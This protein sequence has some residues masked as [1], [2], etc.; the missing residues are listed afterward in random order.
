MSGLSLLNINKAAQAQQVLESTKTVS[1]RIDSSSAPVGVDGNFRPGVEYSFSAQAG[2]EVRIDAVRDETTSMDI[3]M[4]VIPPNSSPIKLDSDLD[5]FRRETYRSS[6]VTT[7]GTW[8]VRI[9]SFDRKPGTFQLSLVIKRDGVTLTPQQPVDPA[10]QIMKD[11]GLKSVVC[12]SSELAIIKIGD[13]TRCT[14]GY[15]KGQYVYNSAAKRLDILDSPGVALVK[16]WG[17]TISSC[18][19]RAVRI[20]INSEEICVNPGFDL[21]SGG[22][23]T[24]DARADELISED[25]GTIEQ[26]QQNPSNEP[27]GTP[28]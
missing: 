28:F 8:K 14:T 19:T 3:V 17:L 22:R 24:Y 18:N 5:G 15:P 12:G 11:L 10:D 6:G 9:V 7:G 16:E 27:S 13:Q 20:R 25:D 2:D 1:G 21:I 4:V 23:Y 26:P